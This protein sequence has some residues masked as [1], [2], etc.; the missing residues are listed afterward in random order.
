M[1]L[2]DDM[3]GA[4]ARDG[5]FIILRE[6]A[7]QADGRL[8]E[9][10]LRRVLDGHGIKRSRDW[11][12]SQLNHLVELEAIRLHKAGDVLIAEIK[13]AGRDHV[14]QRVL[15]PGVTRQHELGG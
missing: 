8:N 7:D 9:A 15:L 1:S 4:I 2:A 14:E 12:V 10:S 11:L 13:S 5:R 3:L 6:L